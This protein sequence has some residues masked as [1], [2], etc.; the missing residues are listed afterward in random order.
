ML[1]PSQL[2]ARGIQDLMVPLFLAPS[3]SLSLSLSLAHT[4]TPPPRAIQH[5]MGLEKMCVFVCMR[6]RAC[7]HV[8]GLAGGRA[9][10]HLPG[11]IPR[12]C[13]FPMRRF[14]ADAKGAPAVPSDSDTHRIDAEREDASKA[15]EEARAPLQG[16]ALDT[17][18]SKDSSEQQVCTQATGA[19]RTRSHTH[20][21][22]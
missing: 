14:C 10:G 18:S 22:A 3:L 5:M 15:V 1:C 16:Q 9:G 7:G 19:R 20:L 12:F 21:V 2:L 4:H 11:T 17:V 8:G 6:V 13:P